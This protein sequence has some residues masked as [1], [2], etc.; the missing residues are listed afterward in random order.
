[1]ALKA[2]TSIFL[3]SI[4]VAGTLSPSGLCALMC[5]RRSQ[6]ERQQHCS[7]AADPMSGMAHHHF[8]LMNHPD[9]DAVTSFWA[10]QSCPTNCDA[11]ERIN[12][13]KKANAQVRMTNPRIGV[14]DAT[15]KFLLSDL[16]AVWCSD[17]GPPARRA[18]FAVSFGILRI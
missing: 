11:V 14:P 10:T 9:L 6:A 7:R 8:A 15:A 17:A 5:E 4:L 12:L 3:L 1:V 13:S 2:P 18:A 16:A